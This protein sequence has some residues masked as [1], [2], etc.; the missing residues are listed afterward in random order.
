MRDVTKLHPKLQKK[1]REFLSKCRE[2]GLEVQIT[3]TL[4]TVEEQNN[5]YAKGRGM[6]GK[7]ITNANGNSYSSM[8]QWGVAFDICRKDGKP[9]FDNSDQ[10]F[11]KVGAIGVSIGLEWGGNW[12]SIVDR[13]H[14]QLA[15]WGST[16]QQLKALFKTPDVF[17]PTW[18]SNASVSGMEYKTGSEGIALIQSFEGCKLNAYL[19]PAGVWTIGYGHTGAV[20]A[21]MTISQ[22][23]ADAFLRAD[24][25]KF[26]EAV[27]K[28]VTVPIHQNQFDALVSFS[29]N[30]GAGALQKSTLLKMLNTGDFVSVAAEFQKWNKSGGKVLLG[31]TRRREAER[32]LFLKDPQAVIREE[33]KEESKSAENKEKALYIKDLQCALNKEYN[34]QLEEDGIPGP[35]TLEA[36]PTL[37]LD[38]CR[39]KKLETVKCI[40]ELLLLKR[41][42]LG[43]ADGYFGVATDRAVRQFQAEKAGMRNPDGEL[44]AKGKSWRLLLECK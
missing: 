6:P 17:I 41:Y 16:P 36:T 38:L 21:N 8:H 27:K 25:S 20:S 12:K 26:E 24:L 35:K 4:R 28:Y 19:C 13:P 9:A 44:T 2:K 10:F 29:Y 39:H 40:Q 32:K 30:C 31:L 14:F 18:V 34:R 43:Q 23:Q 15:Y 33:V 5:L 22:S 42:N 11:E 3:E 37:N 7:I 1:I